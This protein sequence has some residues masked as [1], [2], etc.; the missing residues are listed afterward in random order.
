MPWFWEAL[1]GRHAIP[2]VS[3]S[4]RTRAARDA[5]TRLSL[6]RG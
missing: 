4:A 6:P 3:S 5:S 1:V 2:F